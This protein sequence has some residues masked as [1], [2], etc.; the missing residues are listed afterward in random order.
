VIATA[1]LCATLLLLNLRISYPTQ[2]M[3]QDV[4]TRLTTSGCTENI[5]LNNLPIALSCPLWVHP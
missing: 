3:K 5:V 2:G 1:M 4:Y